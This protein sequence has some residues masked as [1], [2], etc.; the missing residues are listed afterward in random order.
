[1]RSLRCVARQ[2]LQCDFV[3]VEPSIS[4]LFASQLTS[5]SSQLALLLHCHARLAA[6]A[7]RSQIDDVD[8]VC[9]LA[10]CDI[11]RQTLCVCPRYSDVPLTCPQPF[12]LV[13]F[14]SPH[15]FRYRL[16]CVASRTR[17]CFCSADVARI[18]CSLPG[19]S[20]VDTSAV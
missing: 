9:I 12:S 8:E 20:A 17:T 18:C 19:N 16:S 10:K 13:N 6:A 5:F 3:C 15:L 7:F 1:M 11:L 2:R 4:S 14:S